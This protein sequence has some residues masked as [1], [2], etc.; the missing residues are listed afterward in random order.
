M[1]FF[2][3]HTLIFVAVGTGALVLADA[4]APVEVRSSGKLRGFFAA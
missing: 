4:T 2:L 3:V 1:R